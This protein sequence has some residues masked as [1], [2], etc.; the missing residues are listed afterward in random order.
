M[1][2]LLD[3]ILNK[4]ADAVYY[5]PGETVTIAGRF[6]GLITNASKSIQLVVPTVK[7]LDRVTSIEVTSCTGGI[8]YPAGGYTDNVS[9]GSEWKGRSGITLSARKYGQTLMLFIDKSSAFKQGSSSTNV[10]NNTLVLLGG[11]VTVKFS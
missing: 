4:L 1:N 5:Q 10:T 2:G 11:N 9:D 3:R 7:L 6:T 8:R